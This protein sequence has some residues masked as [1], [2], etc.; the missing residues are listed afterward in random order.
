MASVAVVGAGMMGTAFC[1]PCADA[2]HEVRLVGTPLD[3]AII[4]ALKAGRAHPGLGVS[5]A[6]SVQ[7]F[8]VE[9]LGSALASVDAVVLGVSSA[10]IE[11]AARALAS[12]LSEAP[13]PVLMLSKGLEL[14]ARG[15]SVLTDAFEHGIE[16]AVGSR[17]AMHPVSVC[18]PCIAGELARRVPT[19]VVFTGRQPEVARRFAEWV[20]TPYYHVRV[21]ADV[22]GVQVCAALKN[23]FALGVGLASGLHE[24]AGGERGSVAM[25]NYEAAVFA[26]AVLEMQLLVARLGG[27]PATAA[28]L[29]GS[30]DLM[31]TC[32]GGRTGRFG[33]LLGRG[34]G[35]GEAIRRMQG[36]TLE[37]LEVLAVLDRAL[38]QREAPV[39]RDEVPL[40]SHLI[41]I[42]LH[43]AAPDMP[44]GAFARP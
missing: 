21:Q 29:A 7:C 19:Q 33:A 34:I 14:G 5:L 41:A 44:F 18:G 24:S 27:E 30:G 12:A 2:G 6:A 4:D 32:N 17:R 38:S 22:V 26:Q 16:Q 23:A 43:G 1:V 31:V 35:T 37:C 20:G 9:Q 10:G 28:G 15:L 25:H 39:R 3:A 42:G 40:L 8:D 36:A 11:W 13:R